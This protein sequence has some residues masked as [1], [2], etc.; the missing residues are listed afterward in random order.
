MRWRWCVGGGCRYGEL[1]AR[2]ARL[3]QLLAG[4]VG[5]GVGGGAVPGAGGGDGHRV[6]GVWLAGAA[7]VPLDPGYPAERL[8]FM[9]ADSG[10]GL[11]VTRAGWGP[12]RPGG[13]WWTG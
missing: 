12:G 6:L 5:P 8:A 13:W 3:A 9:L 10:A 2:A 4:G 11:L 1:A 7:Y